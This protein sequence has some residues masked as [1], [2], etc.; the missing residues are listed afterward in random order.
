MLISFFGDVI[1]SR[2]P[3]R[4]CTRRSPTAP[5]N[6]CLFSIDRGVSPVSL[7][8]VGPREWDLVCRLKRSEARRTFQSDVD[9]QSSTLPCVLIGLPLRKC[10]QICTGNLHG[11]GDSRSADV[12]CASTRTHS[13]ASEKAALWYNLHEVLRRRQKNTF[14]PNLHT[15]RPRQAIETFSARSRRGLMP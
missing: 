9:T 11:E 5:S 2:Q 7:S 6:L 15:G 4:C 10:A 8:L 1:C 13:L 3:S 12:W 14:G